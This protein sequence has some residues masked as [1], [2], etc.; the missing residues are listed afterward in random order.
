MTV[1]LDGVGKRYGED[2]W[3]VRDIDLELED[4]VHGL[5]GPNGA[6]KSTLMRIVTTVMEPTTGTVTWNGTDVA[7]SP[8]AVREVLGYLPQD[9]GV[10]PDLTAREFLEYVAA[11]RGVD[12]ATAR[13]RI[14]ELLALTGI[15][16]VQDRKIR[17]FSGGMRQ[18]VGIAQAL[19]NDPDLLVVDEPTVGLDPE[20]RVQ[21][22]N[23]LS[24]V[25]D[26]RVV[27]LST[28]I[29]PD[30]EATA[31][32]VALLDDGELLAHTDPESLV[33][34]TDGKVYEF[35]APS[36]ALSDLREA[37]Q[38]SSTVQRADGVR[39]RLIAD[40]PP[41]PEA[42]PVTPTL[43]DAYLYHVG[44]RDVDVGHLESREVA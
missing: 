14:D 20:K 6:G 26:D 11:L 38:V 34:E 8:D 33:A 27:L 9:F 44:A 39:V 24:S 35:L 29:V 15:E 17:T 4:G 10:Y 1:R 3:G 37:Y 21:I 5:L 19:V 28:H 42:E 43:E 12:R 23:L 30:V 36:A 40:E 18:S 2:V 31:H 7:S 22:R 16:D 13:D 25:A 32:R 41:R